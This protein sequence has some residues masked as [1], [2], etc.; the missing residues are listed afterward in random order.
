MRRLIAIA[1]L[2]LS[3]CVAF[4]A[5]GP[6]PV[7]IKDRLTVTLDGAWNRFD[8]PGGD[9]SELWTSEGVSLD[10][11]V[12]YPGVADGET[13]GK[14]R[15]NNPKALPKFRAAMSPSEIAELLEAYVTIDGSSFRQEKLAPSTFAGGPGFRLE[16]RSVRK[17]DEVDFRGIAWGIVRDN[18]LYLMLY[19]APASHYF[20][21]HLA[22][23]EGI[24]ASAAI[25]N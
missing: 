25:R 8:A 22:R 4:T 16:F 10:T 12:F 15:T 7:T 3:A 21:K 2:L 20:Q 24:A 14:P 17:G 13:L 18:R 9:G 19:R 1:S 11:L 5:V 23:V 6:G